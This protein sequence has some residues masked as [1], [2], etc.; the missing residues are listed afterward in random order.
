VQHQFEQ[1]W[2][3]DAGPWV[4][5]S[6]ALRGS[7]CYRLPACHRAHPPLHAVPTLTLRDSLRCHLWDEE[8]RRMMSFGSLRAG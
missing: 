6:T 3:A 5:S 1:A 2:W 4:W 7:S 8:Q